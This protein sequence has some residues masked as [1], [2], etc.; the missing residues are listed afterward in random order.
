MCLIIT[1]VLS[2]LI[3]SAQIY[4]KL[5]KILKFAITIMQTH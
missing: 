2:I 4:Y 1:K 5:D 3:P